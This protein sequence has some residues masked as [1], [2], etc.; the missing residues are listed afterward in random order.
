MIIY[1]NGCSHTINLWKEY[2]WS[3]ILG[4]SILSSIDYISTQGIDD[5]KIKIIPYITW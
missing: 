3:N 1:T 2:S 5:I 4:K